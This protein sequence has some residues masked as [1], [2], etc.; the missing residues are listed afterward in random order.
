MPRKQKRTVS[1]ELRNVVVGNTYDGVEELTLQ[2]NEGEIPCI[3]HS[4][5]EGDAAVVWVGGAGGGLDGPAWGL[6]PR[7]ASQLVHD[8]IVSLRLHYR[9]PNYLTECVLDTLLGAMYLGSRDRT[10]VALVGHSFGGAVV[11]TAGA[12]GES[13]VAVAAL[14]SQT[15]G[16]ELTPD[17][18]PRPLLLM[19]G[20]HDQVLP[21]RCSRD[22]YQRAN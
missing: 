5:P 19:H 6:Y 3:F 17:V 11:I 13:V 4:A 16:T 22:I 14:S 2:T 12:V 1:L 20:T 10:R 9:Y 21:D 8:R 15:Y 7:L 18:S